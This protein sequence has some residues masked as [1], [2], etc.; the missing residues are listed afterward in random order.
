MHPV[1][2][3]TLQF[4]NLT[5]A[6]W[7]GYLNFSIW[8]MKNVLFEKT[9]LNYETNGM[10]CKIRQIMSHISKMHRIFLLPKY[11]K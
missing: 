6:N 10:F 4:R 2:D 3:S 7:D 5:L 1:Q 11:I 9:T 8:F